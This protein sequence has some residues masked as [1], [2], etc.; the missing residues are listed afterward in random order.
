MEHAV[1]VPLRHLGV[2]VVAGVAELRDLLGEQ[3][4]ALGG[5]A[6]DDRSVDLQLKC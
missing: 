6:E 4:N 2:D 3:L 5:V 1:A